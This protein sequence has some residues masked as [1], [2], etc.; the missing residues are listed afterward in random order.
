MMTEIKRQLAEKTRSNTPL[1]SDRCVNIATK[2][3]LRNML[4]PGFLVIFAPLLLGTLFGKKCVS[5]FLV[6][7]ICSGIQLAFSFSTSGSAWDN[8]KKY[9]E[10]NTHKSKE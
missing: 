9:I 10:E 7:L 4:L 6:G 3:S 5:G 2:S 1:N 8:A